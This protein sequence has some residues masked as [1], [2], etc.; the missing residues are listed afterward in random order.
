MKK[1]IQ[2]CGIIAI[3]YLGINFTQEVSA[4]E[5]IRPEKETPIESLPSA[6]DVPWPKKPPIQ[7]LHHPAESYTPAAYELYREQLEKS[8]ETLE[9]LREQKTIDDSA[10]QKG[11]RTYREGIEHYKNNA[12][13]D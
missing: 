9:S 4:D 1:G 2:T 10:Y 3:V 8:R 13:R 5:L 11:I 7:P 6:T 12:I